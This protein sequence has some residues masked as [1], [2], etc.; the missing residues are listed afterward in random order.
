MRLRHH[1]SPPGSAVIAL[2]TVGLTVGATAH[3][4]AQPTGPAT[5]SATFRVFLQ[6]ASI[7]TAEVSLDRTDAGWR[8]RGTSRLGPPLDVNVNRIEVHYDAAWL[9]RGVR[10][11]LST[12]TES[13]VVQG[14]FEAGEAARIEVVRNGESVS[15]GSQVSPDAV[16]LPNLVFSAY[17]A[18]A[19]RLSDA[20]PGTELMV[21]ILPQGE[22]PLRL[23]SVTDETFQTVDR[24]IETRR[25]RVTFINPGEEVPA[26][27]WI[28]GGR[29]A[30][31]DMPGQGLSVAREDVAAVG[32]RI[33]LAARPNDELVTIPASGF[34]LAATV[35]KPADATGELPAVIL[36]GGSGLTDR[37]ETIAGIPI[38]GQLAG[39]LADAGF[40]VL[41]F[42]KRGIGQSGGRV[43]TATLTDYGEDVRNIVRFLRRRDD[44]D[45]DRI[46]IVGYS[47]GAWTG[48]LTADRENR[49]KALV[50]AGSSAM[51][52]A[53]LVREQ[54]QRILDR[55]DMSEAERKE[56]IDLQQQILD[57]VVTG[58]GWEG[59]PEQVRRQADTPEYRSM[60]LFDPLEL[61]R[62]V[63]IPILVVHGELDRQVPIHHADEL[64]ALAKARSR[65]QGADLVKFPSLNH[66]F[67]PAVTGEASEYSTLPDRAISPQLGVVIADWLKKNLPPAR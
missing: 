7:G 9:P 38:F 54:Q 50:L 17:E 30:R 67:V 42:D 64:A 11:E 26:D 37:D 53:D 19:V 15:S 23:D 20:T 4:V 49:I 63:R 22:I 5:G 33:S 43:E 31:F 44:V 35:S 45:D 62:Q 1:S 47:E 41:R 32:S 58:R 24:T 13:V 56:A 29:L 39:A 10:L 18:L 6:G 2:L 25:W 14:A 51:K 16:I 66:L 27:V 12:R 52:G 57:A 48:L 59:I 28:E 34:N 21:Y 3:A 36:V 60:L 55:S 8:I 61:M 40:F 46:A 65:G